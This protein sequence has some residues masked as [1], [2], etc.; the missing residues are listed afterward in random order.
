[1][2]ANNR[3]TIMVMLNPIV[4]GMISH[5]GRTGSSSMISQWGW[6]G[7]ISRWGRTGTYSDDLLVIVCITIMSE[8]KQAFTIEITRHCNSSNGC[9]KRVSLYVEM[10]WWSGKSIFIVVE[11][12]VEIMALK[13]QTCR[14]LISCVVV[15]HDINLIISLR[16][17]IFEWR[18]PLQLLIANY[19]MGR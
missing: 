15:E 13:F 11:F 2:A 5:W 8:L 1:M 3:A 14:N 4:T 19:S 18:Y 10:R 6:T 16:S 17:N 9:Y 7:E 12:S